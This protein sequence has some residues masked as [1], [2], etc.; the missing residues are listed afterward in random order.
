M[1]KPLLLIT[2]LLFL[3]PMTISAKNPELNGT[4]FILMEAETGQILAEN[5]GN[6]RM[7]PASTTKIMTAILALEKLPMDEKIT[8]SNNVLRV[9]GT[10]IYI[11][12]GETLTVEQLVNAL[13]IHSANDAAIVLAEHMAGT[14]EK[15]GEMMTERAKELG[16]FNTTFKNPHGLT[17][18]GH[19][20]TAKDL[21]IIARH[22]M[23]IPKFRE[24]VTTKSYSI[25]MN[26]LQGESMRIVN[27][28]RLLSNFEGSTGIKTGYTY[29]ARHTIVSSA[30][31][32]DMEL[33]AVIFN[34]PSRNTL[35]NDAS[36][37][38]EYG[39]ENFEKVRLLGHQE[40]IDEVKVKYSKANIPLYAEKSL[41]Y[42]IPKGTNDM[43]VSEVKLFAVVKAP[44]KK[45]EELGHVTYYYKGSKIGEVNLL[46][47]KSVK[48]KFYTYYEFTGGILLF[49][50]YAAYRFIKKARTR[51]KYPKYSYQYVTLQRYE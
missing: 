41:S 13:L 30:V 42:V 38:M 28:N 19:L 16:A 33:I 9:I 5:N 1:K 40:I 26:Y 43:L 17:E 49:F 36:K 51:R 32:D 37:L 48:R 34:S 15:F 11:N 12:S 4:C 18:D 29:A 45:N 25:P 39:F 20:T 14:V 24:I 50:S 21:A 2:L 7:N 3:F 44:I 47:S 10:R 35:W 6:M 22:G 27:T 31:R 46:S 23:T 8:A